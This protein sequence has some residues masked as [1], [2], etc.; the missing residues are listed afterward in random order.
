MLLHNKVMKMEN[1][2][3]IIYVSVHGGHKNIF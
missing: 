3:S 2:C 1:K